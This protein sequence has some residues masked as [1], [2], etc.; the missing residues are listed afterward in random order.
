MCYTT[1]K[2]KL[3]HL[4]VNIVI[5]I[6]NL[7]SHYISQLKKANQYEVYNALLILFRNYL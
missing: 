2:N 4:H 3:R 5:T 1:M 7:L 6:R